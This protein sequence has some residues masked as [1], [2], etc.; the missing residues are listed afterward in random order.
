M[1]ISA[2]TLLF[3]GGVAGAVVFSLTGI[4]SFMLLRRKGRALLCVIEE[5][6]Q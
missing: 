4:I 2:G 3:W 5:E 1:T 6:Y